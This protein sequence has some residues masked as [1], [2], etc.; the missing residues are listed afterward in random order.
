MRWSVISAVNNEHILKSCLL[1]S[2][3]ISSADHVILQTGYESAASA[4]NTGMSR[5]DSE[6]V[7]FAHQDVYLPEGWI[8]SVRVAIET[9]NSH[10]PDWGVLGV[11]GVPKGGGRVGYLY[12]TG[13]DGAAGNP[14]NGGIEVET[15]DELLLVVRRSSSL[16]FDEGLPG[17][18]MYGADICL[19]AKQ[20]GLK[21]YVVSAFCIHNTN[22]YKMLPMD[23]WKSY[24]FMR[25]KWK[26]YLPVMTSCIEITYWCWP[27]IKWNIIRAANLL[28]GREKTHLRVADPSQLYR[29]LVRY[30]I[31]VPL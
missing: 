30:R 3:D 16:T 23:F 10:D 7:V 19:E 25:K 4:Y 29:D 20:R 21:C 1:K 12:W 22:Q 5:V 14:F 18:H 13:V 17:F 28:L 26:S 9:L 8:N 11:W 24:F 6:V 2:P 31:V 27:M 15:L